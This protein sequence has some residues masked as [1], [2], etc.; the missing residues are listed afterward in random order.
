MSS[1]SLTMSGMTCQHRA[2]ANREEPEQ[3]AA[4]TNFDIELGRRK[5]TI[6]RYGPG[7]ERR[8]Q[9]CWEFPI[10]QGRRERERNPRCL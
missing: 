8:D 1:I 2:S 4:V 3:V 7:R 6:Q 5:L 9:H 10:N